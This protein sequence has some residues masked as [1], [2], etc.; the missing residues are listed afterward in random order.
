MAERSPEPRA[1]APPPHTDL[2][3]EAE[4]AT[5]AGIY[6]LIVSSA[7]M[8]SVHLPSVAAVEVAVFVT[9]LIYWAAERYARIVAERIH[10]GHRPPWHTVR[11]QLTSGWE[12]ITASLIPLAVLAAVGI[13][14]A[15]TRTA[16]VVALA[17][18][19]VLLCVSGWRIGRGGRLNRGEQVVS[20]AVAG[21]F[22]LGMIALKTLLH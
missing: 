10:E 22:G 8:A 6:G 1:P 3:H 11:R 17:C 9:L 18:S 20:S 21:V 13:L 4:E 12:M 5:A 16:I 14:G 2:A 19:T 15:G 7:V